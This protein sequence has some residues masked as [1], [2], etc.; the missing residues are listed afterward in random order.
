MNK[1]HFELSIRQLRKDDYD[2]LITLWC[3]AGLPFK[4]D[5][6][7]SRDEITRQLELQ[8]SIFLAAELNN[9][10]VGAVLATHDGRK[11]WINRLAVHPKCP[12]IGVARKLMESVEQIFRDCGI[13]I[14]ACL[15][16]NGNRHSMK[17]FTRAGYEECRN[18]I[19]FRKIENADV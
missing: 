11:G 10:I 15:I 13:A 4:P 18:I 5:G 17:F 6:R 7:D 12:V 9:K 3:K 8:N 14:F 1:E 16:E 19:Y 2:N